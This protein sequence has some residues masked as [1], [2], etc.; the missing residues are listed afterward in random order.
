[1][2][3]VVTTIGP[4]D[5][6]YLTFLRPPSGFLI[7]VEAKR[8]ISGRAVGTVTFNSDPND[9]NVLPDLQIVASRPLGNGSTD[10]CDI[11]RAAHRR[12]AG[13]EPTRLRRL[14]SLQQ[15]PSTIS[16]AASTRVRTPPWPVP[17]T[18]FSKPK[19][20]STETVPCSSAP[21]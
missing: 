13:G 12:R 4:E 17:A 20:S 21:V 2:G 6:G 15:M 11:S 3:R 16:A 18:A 9:R 14:A 5:H 7:Y 10:V 8:G 19:T 1:M